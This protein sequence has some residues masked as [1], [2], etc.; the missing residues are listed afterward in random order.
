MRPI[1]A[2][3][4]Q[5]NHLIRALLADSLSAGSETGHNFH[6]WA[7]TTSRAPF[8][9]P[10]QLGKWVDGTVPAKGSPTINPLS[11]VFHPVMHVL[12]A[13]FMHQKHAP[14][15]R[16]WIT[17]HR[18]YPPALFKYAN[19]WSDLRLSVFVYPLCGIK[20]V[21]PQRI[22]RMFGRSGFVFSLLLLAGLSTLPRLREL[23]ILF[24][25]LSK[26]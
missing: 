1:E 14:V 17:A 15:F 11:L 24:L 6:D 3:I 2:D 22:C 18:S 19:F 12:T 4:C 5:R 16:L 13:G 7:S 26:K 25:W 23:G 8:R 9:S 10:V 21:R 20:Y